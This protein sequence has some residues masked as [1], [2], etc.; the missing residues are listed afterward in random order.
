MKMCKVIRGKA[1]H[2]REFLRFRVIY[3]FLLNRNLYFLLNR[4]HKVDPDVMD[5]EIP[6]QP[7]N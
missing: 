3:S 7:M 1:P 6:A 4:N 2:F 5:K